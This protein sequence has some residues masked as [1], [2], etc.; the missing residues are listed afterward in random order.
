[1]IQTK[2]INEITFDDVVK[3]CE[4][5]TPEGRFLD[6]KQNFPAD[7][8]KTIA[9]MANSFGGMIVI[10]VADQDDKPKPP[11]EGM[12][13]KDGFRGKIESGILANISPPVFVEIAVCENSDKTKAFVVIRIPQSNATHA[14]DKVVNYT[15][16][17]SQRAFTVI[18]PFHPLQGQR[19]AVVSCAK[20]W[21]E[22]RI[23]Y[24]NS[25]EQIDNIPTEWTDFNPPDPFVALSA[26]RACLRVAELVEMLRLIKGISG[27]E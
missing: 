24:I 2:P 8:E 20:A 16:Q 3:F 18:H 1:M 17:D 23:Y 6:Y 15:S 27:E 5:Q 22:D 11:Y 10:G 13:Y 25:E 21:G 9:A 26:G 12:A 4:M 14:L 19:F 7:L